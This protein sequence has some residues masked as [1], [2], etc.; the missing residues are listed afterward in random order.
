MISIQP[1]I[2]QSKECG[3]LQKGLC[4]GKLQKGTIY[5]VTCENDTPWTRTVEK[6]CVAV[7]S[8]PADK[9]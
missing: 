8:G 5:T 2:T 1:Q 4:I 7:S 6:A 9:T 3:L